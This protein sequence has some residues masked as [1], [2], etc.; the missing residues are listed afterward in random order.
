MTRVTHLAAVF[1]ENIPELLEDGI[2]YV[3]RECRVAMHNCAC[4]CGEEVSTPLVRT[5]YE[6]ILDD[7]GP[8]IWPSIG[9]HDYNCG[10]H[11]IIRSGKIIWAGKMS[12]KQIKAGRA[13]DRLH[14]RGR[15]TLPQAAMAWVRRLWAALLR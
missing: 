15:Q 6:L 11:Y 2:L 1:V 3:S 5:E 12:R 9:N 4:G 14:K 10:S 7:G 13:Y 8:S